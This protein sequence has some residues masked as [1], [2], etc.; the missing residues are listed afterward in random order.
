[1][2]IL[3]IDW[4]KKK[5]GLAIANIISK[6][7]TV[8]GT[9]SN[10]SLIFDKI[11]EIILRYDIKKIV[12]GKPVFTKTY[13][14]API[15]NEILNFSKKLFEFLKKNNI[16]IDIDYIEEEYTTFLANQLVNYINLKN[17][18]N[19]KSRLKSR[20]D[21]LSAFFILKSYLNV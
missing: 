2:R 20:I 11:K 1:M 17:K 8:I 13:Q 21:G 15:F 7:I 3:G 9:F 4:G 18:E 16:S 19:N 14:E 6:N 5:I 12:I 10:D